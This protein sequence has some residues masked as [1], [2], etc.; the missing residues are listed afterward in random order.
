MGVAG[1]QLKDR[2]LKAMR[3]NLYF[4]PLNDHIDITRH[5]RRP[6][7]QLLEV[8]SGTFFTKG[9]RTEPGDLNQARARIKEPPEKVTIEGHTDAKPCARLGGDATGLSLRPR[10]LPGRRTRTDGNESE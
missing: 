8:T 4:D 1:K 10:P 5:L 7:I 2:L 9:F 6:G 3:R